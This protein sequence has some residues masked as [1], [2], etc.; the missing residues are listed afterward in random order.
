[1]SAAKQPQSSGV[2]H[3]EAPLAALCEAMQAC[4]GSLLSRVRLKQ[5]NRS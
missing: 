1:M 5:A 2:T 4:L 3:G